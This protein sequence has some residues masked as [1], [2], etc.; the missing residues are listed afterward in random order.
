M[1]WKASSVMDERLRFVA[2]LLDGEAMTDV[3]RDF[4]V[5]RK[6]GYKIFDRY[7]EHGLAALSDRSRRPV[8]YANQLPVQIESLIVQL[9]AEKPHWGLARSASSWS[10]GSLSGGDRKAQA[11]GIR[12]RSGM[13][14][15]R[16]RIP[17]GL[18][19]RVSQFLRASM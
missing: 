7:K 3:C 8:R 12:Y 5:S 11:K 19:P 2:R 15:H 4:G 16:I 17:K 9:K 18:Q 10:G 13:H 1:P 6:T 14:S